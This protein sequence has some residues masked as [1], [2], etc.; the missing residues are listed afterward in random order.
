MNFGR[1]I[2]VTNDQ[3][4]QPSVAYIVALQDSGKALELIRNMV[5]SDNEVEDLGH[6]S[7]A[8]LRSLHLSP[9]DTRVLA[10]P[11]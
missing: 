11:L 8:L 7:D 3:K 6:V 2:R 4:H 10:P 9:G 1:L 5:G